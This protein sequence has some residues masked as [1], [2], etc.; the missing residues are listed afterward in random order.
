[1]VNISSFNHYFDALWWEVSCVNS[2]EFG[3][4]CW[5]IGIKNFHKFSCKDSLTRWEPVVR[6]SSLWMFEKKEIISNA[7]S[8]DFWF[9]PPPRF[10]DCQE[11]HYPPVLFQT[12][13]KCWKNIIFSIKNDL[14]HIW[15]LFCYSWTIVCY[16]RF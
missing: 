12:P 5:L 10:W 6:L 14:V 13:Q 15:I 16:L 2:E 1:M 7:N 4:G 11:S 3:I 9:W 8:C